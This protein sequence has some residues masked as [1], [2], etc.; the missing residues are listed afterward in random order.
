MADSKHYEKWLLRA[1]VG[2]VLCGAS[3][4][5]I[6]YSFSSGDVNTEN[7]MMWGLISA[8]TFMAGIGVLA[9]ALVHKVKSDLS[10]KRKH[11]HS[12]SDNPQD[13]A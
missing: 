6:Y 9:S 3:I 7:W 10:R 8:T 1:P 12:D 11:R 4:M 2:I 13:G 5:I